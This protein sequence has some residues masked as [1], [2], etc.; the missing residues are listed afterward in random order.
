ML[1]NDILYSHFSTRPT[2]YTAPAK[3][4]K[5]TENCHYF[6]IQNMYQNIL[7]NRSIDDLSSNIPDQKSTLCFI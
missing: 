2:I 5:K 4:V 1:G 7:H 3:A 6:K